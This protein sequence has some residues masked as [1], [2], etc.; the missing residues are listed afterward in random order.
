MLGG[1][2]D[3]CPSVQTMSAAL[4]SAQV[5]TGVKSSITIVTQSREVLLLLSQGRTQGAHCTA[6]EAAARTGAS[7]LGDERKY[8]A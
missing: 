8:S 4:P 1:K 3:S 2:F 6:S 7:Q 5:A